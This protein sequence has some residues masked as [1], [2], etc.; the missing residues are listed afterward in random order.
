[1]ILFNLAEAGVFHT[2]S[3]KLQTLTASGITLVHLVHHPGPYCGKYLLTFPPHSLLMYLEQQLVNL[4]LSP[5]I[6]L[7]CS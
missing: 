2:K 3:A 5:A 6:L 7:R 4:W 1:M